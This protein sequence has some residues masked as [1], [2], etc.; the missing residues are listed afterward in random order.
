MKIQP[1]DIVEKPANGQPIIEH[2]QGKEEDFFGATIH[3]SEKIL[4]DLDNAGYIVI[5]LE[6]DLLM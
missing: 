2:C 5:P 6:N 1:H 4:S 3:R